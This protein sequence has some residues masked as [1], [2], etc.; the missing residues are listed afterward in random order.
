MFV[1]EQCNTLR[2]YVNSIRKKTIDT[3][4]TKRPGQ[5]RDAMPK[6]GV[7]HCHVNRYTP[8]ENVSELRKLLLEQITTVA[9]VS[10]VVC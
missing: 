7:Y 2:G 3:L 1:A 5:E 9:C 8:W 10:L 6:E 4:D